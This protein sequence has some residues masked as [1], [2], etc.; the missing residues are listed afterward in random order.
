M[1]SRF[2]ARTDSD[3]ALTGTVDKRVGGPPITGRAD[4]EGRLKEKGL[5]PM[6]K[7]DMD[8]V[9]RN[10][11]QREKDLDKVFESFKDA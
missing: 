1:P 2:N 9:E 6:T 3:F 11:P 4:W 10:T 8:N 5:V 7:N